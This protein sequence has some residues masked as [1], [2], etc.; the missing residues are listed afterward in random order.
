MV[1]KGESDRERNGV[2]GYEGEFKLVPPEG[3]WGYL[4]T[5]SVI[6]SQIVSI[7]PLTGF[8]LLYGKFLASIGDETTGTTLSNA[9]FNTV[10]SFTGLTTSYLLRK[11]SYRKV[12]FV[13][14][15]IFSV[16]AFGN[17][18]IEDLTQFIITFGVLQ[19]LGFGLLFPSS[20]S[21]LNSYFSERLNLMNGILN[22]VL[23]VGSILCPPFTAF[24]CDRIG[25]RNTLIVFAALTLLSL[26]AMGILQPVKGHMKK[27]P[28]G[29]IKPT[30]DDTA[31]NN[32]DSFHGEM[33]SEHVKPLLLTNMDQGDTN[34][35]TKDE[36]VKILDFSLLK[37][38]KFLNIIVG[39][40][41]SFNTDLAFVSIIR[42]VLNNLNYDAPDITLMFMV[43]F[44]CDLVCRI[45]FSVMSYFVVIRNRY[46]FLAGSLLIAIFRVAFVL[47]D[48]YAWKIVNLGILGFCRCFIQTPLVL[49]IADEYKTKF[50]TALSFFMVATGIF[51]SIMGP[52][53][54]YVK[55]VTQSDAMVIQVLVIAN[56]ICAISWTVEILYKKF[57]TKR[58]ENLDL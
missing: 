36:K 46:V 11:F 17:I 19:G 5:A 52:L 57:G 34:K 35:D 44:T 22:T 45:C 4:V 18:F 28:I 20:F 8:G 3:G 40:S 16:G 29:I 2:R 1:S 26:P 25:F 56:S 21:A 9:T 32:S 39:L 50:S 23:T 53:M 54:S 6:V 27:I 58:R 24:L 43:H 37:D 51:S 49:V 13:G 55:A 15:I 38:P 30:V 47:R 33:E 42:M 48:D 31:L 14:A 7:V 10:Q 12:G 41:L